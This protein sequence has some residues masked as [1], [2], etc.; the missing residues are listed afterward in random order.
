[1]IC[2][3]CKAT[4]H[5]SGAKYCHKCGSPLSYNDD[6]FIECSKSQSI[7]SVPSGVKA[8]DLGKLIPTVTG[9]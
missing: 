6:R 7:S 3:N 2:P 5:E 9:Q 8:V 4:D 1:M